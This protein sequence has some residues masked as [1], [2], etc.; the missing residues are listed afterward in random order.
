VTS[1]TKHDKSKI[2]IAE[3]LK[4]AG[5]GG[6]PYEPPRQRRRRT[7]ESAP[8]AAPLAGNAGR[9]LHACQHAEYRRFRE[10]QRTQRI[11]KMRYRLSR[12][13]A[14]PAPEPELLSR[15]VGR[16]MARQRGVPGPGRIQGS[17]LTSCGSQTC[18]PFKSN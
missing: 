1:G 7:L 6:A 15:K 16:G 17:R 13:S 3:S 8:A 5:W 14:P 10:R 4:A 18:A 11:P 9:R 12:R 2:E